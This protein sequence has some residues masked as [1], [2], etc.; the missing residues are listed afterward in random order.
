MVQFIL[1]LDSAEN[2][3]GLPLSGKFAFNKHRD[4]NTTGMYIIQATYT[5]RGGNGT[6]PITTRQQFLLRH[7]RL[8]ATDYGLKSHARRMKVDTAA[9]SGFEENHE[10][11]RL[12]AGNYIGFEHIDLTD[13]AFLRVNLLLPPQNNEL[14]MI[15]IRTDA[16]NGLVIGEQELH[17][18]STVDNQRSVLIPLEKTT[19]F[20][21]ILLYFQNLNGG[22]QSVDINT[23]EFLVTIPES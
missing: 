3:E 21:D 8:Q 13:I 4:R 12:D 15:E 9:F 16:P 5:D 2:A 18:G 1:S 7:P 20:H 14:G 6:P 10:I 22:P 17:N 11:I 19:G 23:I